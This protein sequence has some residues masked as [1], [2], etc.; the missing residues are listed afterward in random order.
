MKYLIFTCEIVACCLWLKY[1]TH[2]FWRGFLGI[3]VI[4]IVSQLAHTLLKAR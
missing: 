2:S 3:L 1:G 4:I